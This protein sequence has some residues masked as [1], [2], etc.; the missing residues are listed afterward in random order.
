MGHR[1]LFAPPIQRYPRWDKWVLFRF[2]QIR[3]SETYIDFKVLHRAALYS[4][5]S[6]TISYREAL[7]SL[8]ENDPLVQ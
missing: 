5:F 1:G 4:Y 3:T 7:K 2:C 6:E 8:W